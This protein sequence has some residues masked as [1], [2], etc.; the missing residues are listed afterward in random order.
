MIQEYQIRILPE[1]AASEEGI[2]RYLAKEKGIGCEN[3]E[4]SEGV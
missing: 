4:P 2:K 3:T 1:Q